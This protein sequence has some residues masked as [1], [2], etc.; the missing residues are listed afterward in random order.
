MSL[1]LLAGCTTVPSNTPTTADKLVVPDIV[2]YTK[3]QQAKAAVE[4][5]THC[6]DVPT[7]CLFIN[8]YG[9]MRDQSRVAL[10]M[11]VDINR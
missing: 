7:L 3:A 11:S 5:D 4:M 2:Q 1:L 10:D 6:K 9:K 8:D